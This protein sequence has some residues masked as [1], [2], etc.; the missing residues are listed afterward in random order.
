MAYGVRFEEALLF[1]AQLHRDQTRKASGIPYITHLLAVA[2]L[3]GEAGGGEDEVIAALLHDAL[4]DRPD[5]IDFAELSRRFGQTVA[6]T[7]RGCSDT[8]V[9]PKPP[10]RERK[11]QHLAHLAAA[12]PATLLVVCA[13][14]LHNVQT[15]NADLR[16]L[17]DAL[18]E[19]FRGGKEGTLWYYRA[20]AELLRARGVPS[21]LTS[22]LQRQV[23]LLDGRLKDEA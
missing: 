20:A 17:G 23:A 10:W 14:K 3:V 12:T 22:E 21:R 6:E 15:I 1:A 16:E 18:W 4:E 9:Q 11:E 13:D 19:R 2:A 7:V 8:E 5:A